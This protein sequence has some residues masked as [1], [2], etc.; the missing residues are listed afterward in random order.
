LNEGH[1]NVL[2]V[3]HIFG[4]RIIRDA[5]PSAHAQQLADELGGEVVGDLDH[6]QQAFTARA[7][8]G[9]AEPI[10]LRDNERVELE[11]RASATDDAGL[12]VSDATISE[13]QQLADE[14]AM[15]ERIRADTE[16]DVTE[17]LTR[18]LSA[19]SAVTIH[20]TAIRQ[21][22]TAVTDA[23]ADVARCEDDLGGLGERPPS[24]DVAAAPAAGAVPEDQHPEM[25][26]EKALEQN[27]RAAGLTIGVIVFFLGTGAVL[28]VLGVPV[29]IPIAVFVIGLVVA[30]LSMRRTRVRVH[31]D[32]HHSKR[33]ASELLASATAHDLAAPAEASPP[34]SDDVW[35]ERRAQL[36]T[37]RDSAMERLRSARKHWESLVGPDADPYDVED[38][39]RVRDPQLEL[40]GAASRTS[41]TVRTVSAVHRRTFAR[42]RVAWAGVGYD[43][44]PD[45]DAAD[46]HLD[47]LR[48]AGGRGAEAARQRLQAAQMWS[49]ACATIDRPI[50]L[51]EPE[52]WLA[53]DT[54]ETLLGSLPAGAE[55]IIVERETG[56]AAD[57]D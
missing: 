36:E 57:S 32:D 12:I 54:L 26:N 5:D 16:A 24:A 51:I 50:L 29:F 9:R 4:V 39:L 14:L 44:P 40:V 45:L 38:L 23:E 48:A 2:D 22:A 33:E 18:R 25:F 13:L 49:D 41:P 31:D 55:V 35:A 3:D 7:D 43:E 52:Q 53:E 27:R 1:G 37:L 21:A 56:P 10:V 15:T 28:L 47:R 11:A 20:P 34:P 17:S 6:A 46:A 19:A 42:W 8:A 30:V